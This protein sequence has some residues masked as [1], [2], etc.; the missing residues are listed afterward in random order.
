MG[1]C[2]KC[3]TALTVSQRHGTLAEYCP[4]C[5]RLWVFHGKLDP[6]HGSYSSDAVANTQHGSKNMEKPRTAAHHKY[7]P[8][9]GLFDFLRTFMTR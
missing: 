2:P 7:S 1:K 9:R 5:R 3:N 4:Q 6:E 8:L